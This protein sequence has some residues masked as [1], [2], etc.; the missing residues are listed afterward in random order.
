MDAELKEDVAQLYAQMCSALSDCTRILIIYALSERSRNVT[1]LAEALDVPQPTVSRHLKVLR[2]RGIAVA[3]RDGQS[4][5]YSIPDKRIIE[6]I[7]LLR[8]VLAD[9]LHSQAALVGATN[10][11][12]PEP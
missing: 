1:E 7:D 5:I 6:A 3:Q 10:Q 4:V 12:A 9:I 11:T 2:D 8:N